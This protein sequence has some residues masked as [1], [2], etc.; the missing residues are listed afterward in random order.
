MNE[1][2]TFDR[3]VTMVPRIVLRD[4]QLALQNWP[5]GLQ[6]SEW[7]LRWLGM[8]TLLRTVGH[9]LDREARRAS[10][11]AQKVVEHHWAMLKR[12]QPQPEIFWEFIELERNRILKEYS[13]RGRQNVQA[14]LGI[15]EVSYTYTMGGDGPFAGRSQQEIYQEGIDFWER[16]L[17][18]I[19]AELG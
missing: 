11:D 2:N 10:V 1:Q 12:S 8:V 16:Y 5:E 9:V 18:G 3:D 19:E 14:H 15:D 4:C 13:S 6:G 7:S 17:A